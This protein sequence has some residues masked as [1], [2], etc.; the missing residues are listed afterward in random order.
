VKT[1][2][3]PISGGLNPAL[4]ASMH[5]DTRAIAA[6]L[7][8]QAAH[9]KVPQSGPRFLVVAGPDA[10]RSLPVTEGDTLG[11]GASAQVALHDPAASRNHLRIERR[12]GQL[13]IV[14]LGSKNGVEL[15]GR[16]VRAHAPLHDGDR[17]R[18]GE[19][20]LEAAGLVVQAGSQHDGSQHDGPQRAGLAMAVPVEAG[21][22]RAGPQGAGTQ[23]AGPMR[24]A[25]ERGTPHA[26][27]TA[28]AGE[29]DG[30]AAPA[31]AADRRVQLLR[32]GAA[33]LL[34]AGAALVMAGL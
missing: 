3:V 19:T 21:S 30:A 31:A 33:M 9:G 26:R 24:G 7:L 34:V 25:A 10:G 18:V 29:Q 6:Q 13:A 22:P 5:R 27:G 8:G 14:D 2:A 12:E 23:G 1:P 16:R 32:A 28:H 20:V 4:S 11:R 15:N 17:V